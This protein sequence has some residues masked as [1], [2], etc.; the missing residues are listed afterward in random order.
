MRR[1]REDFEAV[2][3]EELGMDADGLGLTPAAQLLAGVEDEA[4]EDDDPYEPMMLKSRRVERK[5]FG[6]PA[7]RDFCFFCKFK[8]ERN[9]V[10]VRSADVEDLVEFLRSNFG[11]MSST[12]LAAELAEQYAV[13]RERHNAKAR[14]GEFLLPPMSEATI[15][16]HIRKHVQDP[17]W[18]QTVI[19][20]ELQEVREELMEVLFERTR[21]SKRK[22]PNRAA[23]QCLDQT[24]KMELLVQGKDA[25]KMSHYSAG[26]RVS[27]AAKNSGPVATE[28]KR[29]YD[30]FE[31]RH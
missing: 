30:F 17:E 26:A 18:K 31:R 22:R 14:E 27:A 28:H 11:V 21:K 8:G 23:F 6:K 4:R 25:S 10:P 3:L 15:L 12:L 7:K 16:E 20:E 19:L 5:L 24:V 1:S 29:L 13:V 9:T 2:P